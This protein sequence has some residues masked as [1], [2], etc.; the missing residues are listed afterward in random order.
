MV[1]FM[2]YYLLDSMYA[3]KTP[4]LQATQWEVVMIAYL[5]YHFL[6]QSSC[7]YFDQAGKLE[8]LCWREQCI[9]LE[10]LGGEKIGATL[11]FWC[12]AF[13]LEVEEV[14]T[15]QSWWNASSNVRYS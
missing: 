14:W 12:S 11:G 2:L 3:I 1:K 8:V 7:Y 4:S 10:W 5:W 13:Y 6:G 15:Q 9:P